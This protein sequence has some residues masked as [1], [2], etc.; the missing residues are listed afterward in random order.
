[1]NFFAFDLLPPLAVT[2]NQFQAAR[3][4]LK[5]GANANAPGAEG[6]TPLV[7]A[8]LNNNTKMAELLLKYSADPSVLELDRLNETMS[9]VLKRELS[10]LESSENEN[11]EEDSTSPLS[12]LTS[13]NDF[14]HEEEKLV[15][16]KANSTAEQVETNLS[17]RS[18]KK[19]EVP[20]KLKEKNTRFLRFSRFVDFASDRL[21]RRTRH[22]KVKLE[23]SVE[24]WRLVRR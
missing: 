2:K 8:V 22:P 3:L 10:V 11:N 21:N 15:E 7:D 1:M 17:P 6:Q 12:P 20:S 19:V 13:E 24:L 5:S 4:L 9:K 16:E 18:R 23:Q 14:E